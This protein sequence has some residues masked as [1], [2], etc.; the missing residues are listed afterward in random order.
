M[1][2]AKT[3]NN[4][5]SSDE[6]FFIIDTAIKSNLWESGGSD[7]WNNRV[8]NYHKMIKFNKDCAELMFKSNSICKELIMSKYSVDAE[9]YSDTLQVIRWFSG[10]SQPPHA[11][12]M[13][14]TDIDGFDHRSF[15]SILYLNNSYSGGHTYYPNFDAEIIPETGKLAIHPGDPE[16]LH[17][18]TEILDGTRY[19][20]AS[21]WT[22][23]REKSVDWSLY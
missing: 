23:D 8:I 4:I 19:T 6:C 2:N 3:F 22:F 5:L 15:G 1:F 11:D 7:F 17:G 16:H 18:V 14:N 20:I 10:M 13:T 21:F 12:D 9:I